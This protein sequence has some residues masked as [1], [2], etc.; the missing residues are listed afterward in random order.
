MGVLLGVE[1]VVANFWVRVA[2]HRAPTATELDSIG[3]GDSLT[4]MGKGNVVAIGIGAKIKCAEVNPCAA[5][6]LLVN[7]IGSANTLVYYSIF[8]LWIAFWKGFVAYIYGIFAFFRQ[9]R[10]IACCG[11]N[12][13][14]SAHGERIITFE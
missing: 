13:A 9:R 6:H 8:G 4:F 3:R 12:G 11:C 2:S 14:I 1:V 7:M 10:R 5:T